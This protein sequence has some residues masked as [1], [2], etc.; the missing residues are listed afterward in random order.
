MLIADT[1][2]VS[3]GEAARQLGTSV[4]RI[5]EA[6]VDL[7]IRATERRDG[8]PYLLAELFPRFG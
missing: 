3:L 8:V 1:T 6:A 4:E 2:I 7:G 5:A